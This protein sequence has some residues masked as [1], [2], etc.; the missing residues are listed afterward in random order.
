MTRRKKED[1]TKIPRAKVGRVKVT[2]GVKK[3]KTY[4]NLETA[5]KKV[6]KAGGDKVEVVS[7]ARARAQAK[8]A[9]KIKKYNEA[10]QAKKAKMNA[11]AAKRVVTPAARRTAR[12]RARATVRSTK[13]KTGM[14][15]KRYS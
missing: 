10:S 6:R 7:A 5:T 9:A 13:K 3:G 14:G 12:K 4:R 15:K 11:R 8:K 2:S 1:K